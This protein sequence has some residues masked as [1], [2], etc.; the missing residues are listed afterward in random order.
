MEIGCLGNDTTRYRSS[1][2]RKNFQQD[3]TIVNINKIILYEELIAVTTK[4]Q[5]KINDSRN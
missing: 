2:S 3:E 1:Q 4:V 5:K